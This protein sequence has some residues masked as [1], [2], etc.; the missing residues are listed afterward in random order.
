[1]LKFAHNNNGGKVEFKRCSSFLGKPVKVFELLFDMFEDIGMIKIKEK[2]PDYYLIEYI[3]NFDPAK[4]LHEKQ[5]NEMM[6]LIDES[7]AFQK[8]LMEDELEN[9]AHTS[10]V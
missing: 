6:D 10:A 8:N 4:L 7:E 3:G 9:F 2:H 5:Y 1:M